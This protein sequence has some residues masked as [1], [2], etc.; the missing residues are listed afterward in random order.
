MNSDRHCKRPPYV[1]CRFVGGCVHSSI[2]THKSG[3]GDWRRLRD[4]TLALVCR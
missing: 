2:H 3:Y 1:D 4:D